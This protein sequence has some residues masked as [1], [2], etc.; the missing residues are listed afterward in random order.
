MTV[1]LVLII[2]A[3][4]LVMLVFI[5]LPFRRKKIDVDHVIDE[6]V[7]NAL[8]T[9]HNRVLRFHQRSFQNSP[10]LGKHS[11]SGLVD[12]KGRK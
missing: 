4:F 7:K 12:S 6:W 1:P 2:L 11:N 8:R 9:N 5:L 3:I 10:D